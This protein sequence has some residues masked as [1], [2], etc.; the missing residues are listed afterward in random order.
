M[1]RH[2]QNFQIDASPN[3]KLLGVLLDSKLTW[4]AQHERVREKAVKWTMAF[5]RF[6]RAASDI[7]MNEALKLYNAVAIPKIG[8][9]QTSGF[10][11]R[12]WNNDSYPLVVM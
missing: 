5:K 10:T 2:P 11:Q 4:A 7:R 1:K 6:T 12:C 8:M 9:L 3:A